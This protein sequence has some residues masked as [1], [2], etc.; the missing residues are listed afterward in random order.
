MKHSKATL[1]FTFLLSSLLFIC[2]NSE[3]DPT[4]KNLEHSILS[5]ASSFFYVNVK[6]YPVKN[7]K[8]PIGIFD[9]GTGGLTVMDAIVNYDGFNNQNKNLNSDGILD[10]EKEYFIY[11]ADQAN[12]PYGNYPSLN[13]TDVLKEHILKDLQFLLSNKYYQSSGDEEFK[14]DKSPVK[15][16][17]IACNTATAYGMD[18]IEAFLKKAKLD[19]QV[20][21]VINAGVKGAFENISKDEDCSIGVMATEGT[22]LSNGYLNTINKYHSDLNY[23]GE[24]QT[25][26]QAGIGL[27]G[28]ID[29][30][31][32]YINTQATEIRKEYKGPSLTSIDAKIDLSI[33]NRYNFDW[34]NNKILYSGEK[35]NPTEIQLNSIEN[36]IYYN[37]VS[38]VE[39]LKVSQ[40]TKPLK[41]IILGCTHY[42]FY[43][44]IFAQKLDELYNLKENEKYVYRNYMHKEIKLIDPALNT[45][46][47][48]YE[49]LRENNL[50][51]DNE[52]NNS[53]FYI[54]VPNVQNKNIKLDSLGNFTYEYKYGRT[55][56]IIHEYVKQVPFNKSN[57]HPDVIDMLKEKTPLIFKLITDFNQTNSK[58]EFIRSNN[59]VIL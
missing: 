16:I 41:K 12:M 43:K 36:Y 54:S 14:I 31:I 9:S 55:A 2:C 7:K 42:P 35:N 8:L 39:Q 34:S 28:A 18:D 48:L 38:L 32:D 45:A 53:E 59:L 46:K 6:N 26:Q 58:A 11:L 29:G 44:N 20:I 25:F 15:A 56:G 52:L 49:Y 40:T 21:G 24:I 3:Q 47:E 23:K 4:T 22:V 57:L 17:V 19:I 30:V 10:F 37:V 13:K 50:F 51:G 33:L 1:I 27:A 5:D